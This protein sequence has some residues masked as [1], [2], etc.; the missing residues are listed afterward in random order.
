[1]GTKH[2][3]EDGPT[4]GFT[5][6]TK[7]IIKDKK[8]YVEIEYWEKYVSWGHSET[9]SEWDSGRRTYHGKKLV[10]L[11]TNGEKVAHNQKITIKNFKPEDKVVS[12][13]QIL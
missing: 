1:M 12:L 13:K 9:S 11:E 8:P 2:W 4:S 6:T 3:W 7:V 10:L 5:E